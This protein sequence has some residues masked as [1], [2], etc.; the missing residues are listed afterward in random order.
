M[1]TLVGRYCP[2]KF[3]VVVSTYAISG[4]PSSKFSAS[5]VP[6]RDTA[7]PPNGLDAGVLNRAVYVVGLDGE[8]IACAAAPPSD[9]ELKVSVVPLG[10]VC[11]LAS[12]ATT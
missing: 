8:T 9:H 11:E 10:R 12:T 1:S 3:S 2:P 5:I 7:V 4:P 6:G